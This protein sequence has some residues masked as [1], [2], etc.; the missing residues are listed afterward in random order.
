MQELRRLKNAVNQAYSRALNCNNV[1]T[2]RRLLHEYRNLHKQY[3]NH[4][5]WVQTLST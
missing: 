1:Q 4:K 3:A 2:K 5:Q